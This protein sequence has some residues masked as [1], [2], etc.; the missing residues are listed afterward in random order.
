[1]TPVGILS[2]YSLSR[3]GT[4]VQPIRGRITK[5]PEEIWRSM[6]VYNGD[7]NYPCESW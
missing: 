2:L 1:M 7:V 3:F 6:I 5:R 4:L